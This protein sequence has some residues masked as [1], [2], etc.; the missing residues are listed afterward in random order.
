MKLNLSKSLEDQ[1]EIVLLSGDNSSGKKIKRAV[2][3]VTARLIVKGINLLGA[4][5]CSTNPNS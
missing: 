3:D 2:Y 4:I 5:H 1:G